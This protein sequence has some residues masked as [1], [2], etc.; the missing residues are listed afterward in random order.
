MFAFSGGYV[1]LCPVVLADLFG[2]DLIAQSLGL[3]MFACGLAGSI[4]SPV[5]GIRFLNGFFFN[6]KTK[7]VC[8]SITHFCTVLFFRSMN[9]FMEKNVL[10][11]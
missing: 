3:W 10:F 5:G 7:R 9:H 1:V 4:A 2:T 6:T 8:I 11:V